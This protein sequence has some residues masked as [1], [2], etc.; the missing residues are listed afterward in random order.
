MKMSISFFL[1]LF[2]H[3]HHLAPLRARIVQGRKVVKFMLYFIS[4]RPRVDASVSVST[5][6]TSMG[7]RHFVVSLLFFRGSWV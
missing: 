1:F 3:F 6:H 7:G 2:D 4:K 5:S